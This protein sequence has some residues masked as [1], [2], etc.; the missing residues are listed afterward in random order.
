MR[1]LQSAVMR[2]NTIAGA[3]QAKWAP[4]SQY[5]LS[6]SHGTD[7]RMWDIRVNIFI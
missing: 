2:I 6:T 1:N 5:F 7:I 4:L 3:E